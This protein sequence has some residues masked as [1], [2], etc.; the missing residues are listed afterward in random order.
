MKTL[1][2]IYFDNSDILFKD[3]YERK[4][5]VKEV[6]KELNIT[7]DLSSMDIP[8][9]QDN[10]ILE[11][12]AK[13]IKENIN[14]KIKGNI[15]PSLTNIKYY[16][17]KLLENCDNSNGPLSYKNIIELIY[18]LVFC[19]KGFNFELQT[20]SKNN[21]EIIECFLMNEVI[22]FIKNKSIKN[23]K[24]I[25]DFTKLNHIL[26]CIDDKFERMCLRFFLIL[27]VFIAEK[28]DKFPNYSEFITNFYSL[29]YKFR[30]AEN[31]DILKEEILSKIDLPNYSQFSFEETTFNEEYISILLN[32]LENMI[33]SKSNFEIKINK[34]IFNNETL[35]KLFHIKKIDEIKIKSFFKFSNIQDNYLKY[36]Q[37]KDNNFDVL[38]DEL[39]YD[40]N[41]LH[42]FNAFFVIACGLLDKIEKDSLQIFNEGNNVITLFKKYADC[43]LSTINDIIEKIKNKIPVPEIE[44]NFGF[45]KIFKTFFVLFTDLNNENYKR[46]KLKFDLLNN[47]VEKNNEKNP[48]LRININIEKSDKYSNF[49][50]LSQNSDKPKD[51]EELY[52]EKLNSDSLEEGCRRYILSRITEVID[53]KFPEINLIEIFKILFGLNFFIPYVDCNGS[54]LF[55]PVTKKLNYSKDNY[56]EYG[57]QEFDMMFK[58]SNNNDIPLNN[59][60][61]SKFLPFVKSTQIKIKNS[62]IKIEEESEFFIKKN[63]LVII[64][65][66]IKFPKSKEKLISYI[67]IM[68]KKLV[69][70]IKLLKNIKSDIIYSCENI[71]LLLI[72]D[73][74]I[75]RQNEIMNYINKEEIKKIMNEL[76]LNEALEFTIEIVYVSQIVHFYNTLNDL[77]E[78]REMKKEIQNLKSK[79]KELETHLNNKKDI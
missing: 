64:E 5:H 79:V 76:S 54:L 60:Y 78:R 58:V 57:Y 65:N 1:F 4:I 46:K 72:Y 35:L 32:K 12:F 51:N 52:Y 55:I 69:F 26:F 37:N 53:D 71:Q 77:K 44:E 11:S 10:L 16:Y 43:L 36:I 3:L 2:K 6:L 21:K 25:S 40:E 63:A 28:Y 30:K 70:V 48:V 18:N 23:D 67:S 34:N 27:N 41:Y 17:K 68:I 66:K 33:K 31:L 47:F 39:N 61:G 74:I 49:T 75:V 24:D 7:K 59:N 14:Y 20:E 15:K 9:P 22:A 45:G 62:S 50:R 73:E 56:E 8:K 29:Y 13:F 42:L 19:Q 38:V